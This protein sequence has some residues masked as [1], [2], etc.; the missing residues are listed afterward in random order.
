MNSSETVSE[1]AQHLSI[2]TGLPIIGATSEYQEM[3]S[4]R[5]ASYQFLE[6][7]LLSDVIAYLLRRYPL[8]PMAARSPI[9]CPRPAR[10]LSGVVD[11]RL[12]PRTSIVSQN[13]R[14]ASSAAASPNSGSRAL[15]RR[16]RT[17]RLEGDEEAGSG[18][19][20]GCA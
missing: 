1:T 16:T 20:K 13:T 18:D 9:P 3:N 6:Y 10:P 2:S 7:I 15:R 14:S 5:T 8:V 17:V 11:L 12:R 19:G 4:A